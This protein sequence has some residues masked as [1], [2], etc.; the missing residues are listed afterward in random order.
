[1]KKWYA[2]YTKPRWEKKIKEDLENK[3]IEVFL[4]LKKELK[5]WS[6]RKKWVYNPLFSSYVFVKIDYVY[7]YD[8][9]Q[10][11]GVLKFVSFADKV[12]PVQ[13]KEIELIKLLLDSNYILEANQECFKAGTDVEIIMGSLKGLQGK[14]IKEKNKTKVV[15]HIHCIKYNLSLEIDQAYLKEISPVH[16]SQIR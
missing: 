3:N 9:L 7:R 16:L 6:D 12:D 14:V 8:V 10:T 15:I 2:I 11:D 5:Q 4:P 1:M 13:E